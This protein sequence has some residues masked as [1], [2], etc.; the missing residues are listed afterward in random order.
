MTK[1]ISG[2]SVERG[3]DLREF[4]LV[5]FGG[6]CPLHAAAL[7][8]ELNIPQVV[9]PPMCGDL[10]AFGL[11]VSDMQHDYNQTLVKTGQDTKPQE[12]LATFKAL[13]DKG[14]GVIIRIPH[15]G[16]ITKDMLAEYLSALKKYILSA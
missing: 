8:G 13:E 11:V 7:A 2:V 4:I 10:A 15:M 12:L 3:Y 14:E 16:D 5:A 1:G 6:A 9:V